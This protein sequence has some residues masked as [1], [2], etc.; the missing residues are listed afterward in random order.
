M[1]SPAAWIL[2][3]TLFGAL[4]APARAVE[5]DTAADIARKL[6]C[7]CGTCSNQ[8]IHD[9]TCGTAGQA[10]QEIRD[11]LD[12]AETPAEIVASFTERFGEQVLIAPTKRGFNLVAWVT[13]FVAL[14]A[15][16]FGLLM[17]IRRW[18]LAPV[19]VAAETAGG[20]PPVSSEDPKLLERLEREIAEIED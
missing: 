4:I 20:L 12:R 7:Y 6:V 1:G 3:F 15:A 2:S 9:C 18:S 5:P 17:A 11:R 14:L 8:T 13:P 10:R 19:G 16:S